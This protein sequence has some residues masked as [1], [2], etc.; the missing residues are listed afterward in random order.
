MCI[1]SQQFPIMHHYGPVREIPHRLTDVASVTSDISDSRTRVVQTHGE[2]AGWI[3]GC[4][5][6]SKDGNSHNIWFG[7]HSGDCGPSVK[8]V[9]IALHG[10]PFQ[11]Y[12]V[13]PAVWDPSQT[14]LPAT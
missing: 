9:S 13:S 3:S 4:R 2:F 6:N 10:N 5:G 14:V 12:G 1:L 8:K 7:P 11:S